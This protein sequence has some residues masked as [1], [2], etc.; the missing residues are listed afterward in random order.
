MKSQCSSENSSDILFHR[1][2][3]VL[4]RCRCAFLCLVV[5]A[6]CGYRG[7]WSLWLFGLDPTDSNVSS[8]L[9]M[10]L[11][12]SGI[13]H[14]NDSIRGF[15]GDMDSHPHVFYAANLAFLPMVLASLR[16]LLIYS[17][18]D[19]SAHIAVPQE[20]QPLAEEMLTCWRGEVSPLP[21]EFRL[22][23]HRQKRMPQVVEEYCQRTATSCAVFVRA[24][25]HEYLPGVQRVPWLD[26]DTILQ[27]DVAALCGKEMTHTIAAR[28]HRS[29]S[30][31]YLL[32]RM[33]HLTHVTANS[34]EARVPEWVRLPG[35]LHTRSFNTG[36]LLIDLERWRAQELTYFE[37]LV[38]YF[39]QDGKIFQQDQFILNV[40]FAGKF[41][42]LDRRWNVWGLGEK[43]KN[44]KH[45]DK[46]ET[47]VRLAWLLHWTGGSEHS[48]PTSKKN[49]FHSLYSPH[50]FHGSC[51]RSFKAAA[52]P[53]LV[54]LRIQKTGSSFLG[55]KYHVPGYG[56]DCLWEH[57]RCHTRTHEALA[58]AP[59]GVFGS[60]CSKLDLSTCSQNGRRSLWRDPPYADWLDLS[61]AFERATLDWT[62]S[63][64]V[65]AL[66][67]PVS[68][69]Q[70]EFLHVIH[71]LDNPWCNEN[72][73]N[74][75]NMR[76][77]WD[78]ALPCHIGSL[79]DWAH[80][81]SCSPGVSNRQTRFLAGSGS[82]DWQSVFGA[83]QMLETAK[84]HLRQMYWFAISERMNESL[85]LLRCLV[86]SLEVKDVELE[87]EASGKN[88]QNAYEYAEMKLHPKY[89]EALDVL[90]S[91]NSLD[92]ELYQYASALLDVRLLAARGMGCR[93]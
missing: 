84:L 56:S 5:L 93:V 26:A 13:L 86:P 12:D 92:L 17:N 4:S 36:V 33:S 20:E 32:Q 85:S 72:Q 52:G 9:L 37:R 77:A 63:L 87:A 49:H 58:M 34:S 54:I 81:D 89:S 59:K 23:L 44:Q 30:L 6:S 55:Y 78:Y 80:C 14:E 51:R 19:L 61:K 64:L 40:M 65:T 39:G 43:L 41:Q 18:G 47:Q 10:G 27:H 21:A 42:N 67:E 91:K 22:I 76:F 3:M 62:G 8:S 16:S 66:R 7:L 73:T 74:Q 83:Q 48:K 11:N 31:H 24:Y 88:S 75:I 15:T 25:L 82:N 45:V 28:T 53:W 69:A 1:S 71:R 68:R 90:A 57:C 29:L 2:R 70:S 60:P 50:Q 38:A 46:L 35:S 79:N